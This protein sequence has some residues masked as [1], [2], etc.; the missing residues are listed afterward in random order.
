MDLRTGA[1]LSEAG[2]DVR[3]IGGADEELAGQGA[4]EAD[5]ENAEV[6]V[7]T[8]ESWLELSVFPHGSAVARWWSAEPA[9]VEGD[10]ARFKA[11]DEETAVDLFGKIKRALDGSVRVRGLVEWLVRRGGVGG[12][13]ALA[14]DLDAAQR[15]AAL[16][17]LSEEVLEE[18][19]CVGVH[20]TIFRDSAPMDLD[21]E[22]AVADEEK[23]CQLRSA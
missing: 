18:L 4:A 14:E 1:G 20:G 6:S 17:L 23:M 8:F 10:V 3:L 7:E 12:A 9:G 2:F 5:D 11:M 21:P 13:L 22:G 19:S 16:Q 15:T